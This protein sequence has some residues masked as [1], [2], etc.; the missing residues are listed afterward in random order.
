MASKKYFKTLKEAKKALEER[1][2][3][4]D[5]GLNIYKM[6]KGSRHAHMYA[7]CTYFEYL[8]TY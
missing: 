4:Y 2:K 6:P 8:N 1:T 3:F 7:V 5:S